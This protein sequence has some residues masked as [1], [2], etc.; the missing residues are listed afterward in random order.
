[1]NRLHLGILMLALLLA[2][3]SV[4]GMVIDR[5]HTAIATDLTAA[6]ENAD[7]AMASQAAKRWLRW[8]SL[9][10]AVTDHEPLEHID[11]LFDQLSMEQT[12]DNAEEFSIICV[13]LAGVSR[14]IAESTR[15]TWWNFL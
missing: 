1:M 12:L 4:T 10:A 5:I 6:A 11:Q 15:L 7:T 8:R 9:T 3:S 13:Q 14:A 2:L